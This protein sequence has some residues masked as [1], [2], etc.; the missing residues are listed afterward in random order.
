MWFQKSSNDL[1]RSNVLSRFTVKIISNN[2]SKNLNDWKELINEEFRPKTRWS[3]DV[4]DEASH[5]GNSRRLNKSNIE[6]RWCQAVLPAAFD[7][8]QEKTR[9]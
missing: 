7:I 1:P 5:E 9:L 6:T 2:I 8:F 3:V 4:F